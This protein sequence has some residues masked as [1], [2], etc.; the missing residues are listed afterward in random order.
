MTA[1]PHRTL[2]TFRY[3]DE[4]RA[5]RVERSV[6]PEL[7]DIDGDRT[8]ATLARDGATLEVTV[9]ADDL[10]ALRAGCNTWATLVGVAE[11]AGGIA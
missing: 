7:G 4:E 3:A 1:R 10:V 11:A 8:T 5:R 6:R 2:L 9:L